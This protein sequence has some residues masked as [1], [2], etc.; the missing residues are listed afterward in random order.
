MQNADN[1]QNFSHR[2][3]SYADAQVLINESNNRSKVQLEAVRASQGVTVR[4]PE[5]AAKKDCTVDE[6]EF[7]EL[8]E[9]ESAKEVADEAICG[10]LRRELDK[11]KE[12]CEKQPEHEQETEVNFS[13]HPSPGASYNF[14]G[15]T[16][17]TVIVESPG[18]YGMS[19]EKKAT[20]NRPLP[21]SVVTKTIDKAVEVVKPLIQ[22]GAIFGIADQ[23]SG[24][25]SDVA[26]NA[27]ARY[28]NSNNP[29]LSDNSVTTT[30]TVSEVVE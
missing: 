25:I 10:L 14:A 30:T 11:K 4:L 27:G 8:C 9:G 26:G 13:S 1:Q 12:A 3:Q 21:E 6:T 7:N 18:A 22:W 17:G 19:N 24:A 15:A 28:T 29:D 16:I 5:K 23:V 20:Q 2:Y